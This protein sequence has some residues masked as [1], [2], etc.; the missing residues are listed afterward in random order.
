MA[1]LVMA[2]VVPLWP[3][4]QESKA[5]TLLDPAGPTEQAWP[6]RAATGSVY[7]ASPKGTSTSPGTLGRPLDL[8]TALSA[9]GPIH[10]GDV[11]WLRKGIYR[12]N[13]R[14]SLVGTPGALIVVAA[15]PGERAV[16]DGA[17]SPKES[18]LRVDGSY[19]VYWGLEFT[20]SAPLEPDIAR[21]TGIDVFGPYTKFINV[22][23]HHTG[24]G[25]GMWTP[26]LEVEL[27]GSLIYQSGWEGADRGHGHSIYVQNDAPAKRIVDN[28]LFDGSSFGVHAYTEGGDI[29]NVYLEG[30][31]AFDHG[32]RSRVSGP[33]ANILVGGMRVARH[34][35]LVANYAYYPEGSIGRNADVGYIAGCGDALIA[36]NYF[37]GGV[38]IV[39][40]RCDGV[41]MTDN[42]FT[43]PVAAS[44]VSGFPNNRYGKDGPIQSQTFVRPNRYQKGRANVAIFNWERRPTVRVNLSE[45]GLRA[46]ERFEI[47]DVRNYFGKPLAAGVYHHSFID[48]S[49][50]HMVPS[51]PKRGRAGKAEP[52]PEFGAAVVVP[53]RAGLSHGPPWA[54]SQ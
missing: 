44:V 34:P 3:D 51:E 39:L 46:G 47:R 1:V 48:L 50:S 5:T 16:L 9:K 38:P 12:G 54:F 8:A 21:G 14:S 13:F 20:N 18:V 53:V 27:Y 42:T 36:G 4:V 25:I 10:A 6:N 23:V 32:T 7:Y 52:A 30:N 40:T 41:K 37:A 24:N 43:G 28:I 19:T 49:V 29:N 31:I 45:A 35:V 17:P 11:L 15:L 33:K 2:S 22:V 26:A